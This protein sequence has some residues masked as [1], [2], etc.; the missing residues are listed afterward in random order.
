MLRS[1][2]SYA[3]VMA[4]VAVFIALGGTSYAAITITVRAARAQDA[5]RQAQVIGASGDIGHGHRRL[6]RRRPTVAG[7]DRVGGPPLN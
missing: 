5:R 7:P 6:G 4:T 2:L 1:H 3:N